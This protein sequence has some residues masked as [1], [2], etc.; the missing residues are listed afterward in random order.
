LRHKEGAV[1]QPNPD[2]GLKRTNH[3][4]FFKKEEGRI[5]SSPNEGKDQGEYRNPEAGPNEKEETA[6]GKL[7]RMESTITGFLAGE[8]RH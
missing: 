6:G 1:T 3:K 8:I 5:I 2:T 4:P 7:E